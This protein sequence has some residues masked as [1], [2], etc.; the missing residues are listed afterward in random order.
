[1]TDTYIHICINVS[2]GIHTHMLGAKHRF[3]Q[4]MDC[5][6]QSMDPCFALSIHGL[7]HNCTIPGLRTDDQ[8]EGPLLATLPVR[9]SLTKQ[10][11]TGLRSEGWSMNSMPT[12][13]KPEERT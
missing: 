5:P 4:S 10:C 12:L 11:G 13:L 6:A 9:W 2:I 7:T 3:V 1:M 8:R